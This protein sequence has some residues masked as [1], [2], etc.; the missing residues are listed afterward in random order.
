[1]TF[2]DGPLPDLTDYILDVLKD[3]QAKATFFCVG[4]NITKYPEQAKKLLDGGHIIGNH[5]FNHLK[6]WRVSTDLYLEN[7]DKFRSYFH[8]ILGKDHYKLLFRPPHGQLKR[9]QIEMLKKE[10]YEIIMWD[11]LSYDFSKDLNNSKAIVKLKQNTRK[12]SIIVFHDNYKAKENL[13]YLLPRYM[14]FL[15]R[16]GY[17]FGLLA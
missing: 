13:H 12:G 9:R 15:V 3:Y 6:G 7:I 14:D 4:E 8:Q 11:L 10:G 1:M 2:D 17:K 5:T 16:E